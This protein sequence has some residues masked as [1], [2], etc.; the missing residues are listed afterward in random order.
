MKKSFLKLREIDKPIILEKKQKIFDLFGIQI[1]KTSKDKILEKIKKFL[2]KPK[3]ILH[4]VSLNPE[5][6][7]LS[8][9]DKEFKKIINKGKIKI[10]DGVGVKLALYCLYKIKLERIPGVDLFK[11][12][13]DWAGKRGYRIILIGGK[14]KVAEYIADCYSKKGLKGQY[15]GI[16][17]IKD[18]NNI[19]SYEE[20]KIFSIISDFKPHFVFVAFGSPYQE[21]WI[22][23]NRKSF[24]GMI[25]MG[26]GGSF[27]YV[28]GRIPRPP[29][30]IR[31][32]GLEWLWRLILQPW[33]AKR[34]LRLVKFSFLVLKEV[35]CQKLLKRKS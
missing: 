19:K 9:K 30:L 18:I 6:L 4:I 16:E 7:I 23:K 25:V 21:K 33:R 34:Q 28:S 11:F 17:G 27:D 5:I 32:I 13:M 1:E 15:L 3:G 29:F 2:K 31:R 22:W 20:D 12:L 24:E 35:L 26:V 8:T 14:N 10:I